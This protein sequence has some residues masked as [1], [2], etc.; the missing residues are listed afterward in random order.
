M[1]CTCDEICATYD[2]CACILTLDD[3]KCYCICQ[4]VYA[5]GPR[6]TKGVEPRG[7]GREARVQVS[8]RNIPLSDLGALLAKWCDF[9]I[10]V[11]ARALESKVTETLTNVPLE[12]AIK[13]LGMMIADPQ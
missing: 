13:E 6:R 9:E 11:P 2:H 10:L 8:T 12:S 4:S 5:E 1:S 7:L 3:G